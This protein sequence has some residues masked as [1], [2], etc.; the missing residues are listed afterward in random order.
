VQF[1]AGGAEPDA[2]EAP[3]HHFQRRKLLR[4]EEHAAAI[5]HGLRDDVGDGLALARARRPLDDDV[6][7]AAHGF[8]RQRLAAIDIHDVVQALDRDLGIHIGVV[9]EGRRGGQRLPAHQRT[10]DRMGEQARVGRGVQVP[11]HQ[12][13]LEAEQPDGEAISV[14]RPPLPPTQRRLHGI[15][16]GAGFIGLDVEGGQGDAEF[17]GELLPQGE[18]LLHLQPGGAQPV[19]LAHALPFQRHGQQGQGSKTLGFGRCRIAPGQRADGEREG[20]DTR[21]LP[22]RPCILHQVAQAT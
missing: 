7:G 6:A 1:Q 15:G 17:G 5:Q 20:G 21:L 10:H 11:P 13:L 16:P 4:H 8:R 12:E 9:G 18:V 19:G 14:H 2:A 22:R 3:L